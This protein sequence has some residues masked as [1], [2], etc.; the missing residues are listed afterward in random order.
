MQM[1]RCDVMDGLTNGFLLGT[2]YV[3]KS[4]YES[5]YQKILME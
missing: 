3:R 2:F 1:L 5:E 4:S